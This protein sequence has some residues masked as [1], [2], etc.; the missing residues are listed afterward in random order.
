MSVGGAPRQH[1]VEQQDAGIDP[2]DAD[3]PVVVHGRDQ[4]EQRAEEDDG[5]R[6]HRR[7]APH[8][9]VRIEQQADDEGAGDHAQQQPP[10]EEVVDREGAEQQGADR[11][12]PEKDL[13]AVHL[14]EAAAGRRL[15]VSP[16]SR[17]GTAWRTLH[18]VQAR[19]PS[20]GHYAARYRKPTTWQTP[21]R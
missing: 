21:P 12:Q 2:Q 6:H 8:D 3:Q 7:A 10:L 13:L 11:S 14:D 16:D 4:A 15:P 18:I 19:P 17:R 1:E 9:S 5:G 20:R